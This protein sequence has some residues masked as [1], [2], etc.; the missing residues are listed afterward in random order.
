MLLQYYVGLAVIAYRTVYHKEVYIF[1]VSQLTRLVALAA[2]LQ[3]GMMSWSVGVVGESH[4]LLKLFKDELEWTRSPSTRTLITL[5]FEASKN[6]YWLL[7]AH[8]L[9]QAKRS[10]VASSHR[11][12]NT[13]EIDFCVNHG[14]YLCG[15]SKFFYWNCYNSFSTQLTPFESIKSGSIDFFSALKT[16]YS[17]ST[18]GMGTLWVDG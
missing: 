18:L 9:D 1:V 7:S 14:I 6:S 17:I 16:T 3:C 8:S 11:A 5:F 12:A 10:S 4:T 15:A 2:P 13:E